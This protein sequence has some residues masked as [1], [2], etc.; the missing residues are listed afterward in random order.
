MNNAGVNKE[1]GRERE[2]GEWWGGVRREMHTGG[3]GEEGR[4]DS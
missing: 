3:D 2:R 4:G 1:K